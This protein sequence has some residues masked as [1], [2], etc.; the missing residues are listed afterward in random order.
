MAVMTSGEN[1]LTKKKQK[2]KNI[3]VKMKVNVV[4]R[5]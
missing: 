4:E 3:Q 2:Q 5:S 1:H